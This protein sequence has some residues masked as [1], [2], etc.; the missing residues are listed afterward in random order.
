MKS[1]IHR[2]TKTRKEKSKSSAGA[3]ENGSRQSS[4]EMEHYGQKKLSNSNSAH[5]N[6]PGMEAKDFGK[7]CHIM[8]LACRCILHK[9]HTISLPVICCLLA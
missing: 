9:V 3:S 8:C 7:V 5:A 2:W 1:L 6:C 4:S